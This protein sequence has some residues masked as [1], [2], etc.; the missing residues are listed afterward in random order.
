MVTD[1]LLNTA[2]DKQRQLS[3]ATTPRVLVI[4]S[5][6]VG[7]GVLLSDYAAEALIV[8][9]TKPQIT[10]VRSA[11][12]RVDIAAALSNSVFL[13]PAKDGHIAPARQS[14]SAILLAAVSESRV[15]LLGALHP[16]PTIEF[17]QCHFPEVAF[18]KLREWNE[19]PTSYTIDWVI[20]NPRPREYVLSKVE[21]TDDELRAK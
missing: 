7:A 6:H 5:E 11:S 20:C 18:A 16:K 14:I 21:L 12:P 19:T 13:K 9:D 2:R 15:S 4:A 10:G 1:K 17:E 3:A 8:G